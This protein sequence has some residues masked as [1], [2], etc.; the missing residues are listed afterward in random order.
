MMGVEVDV[1]TLKEYPFSK[2]IFDNLCDADYEA[3]KNDI[4]KHGIKVPLHIL[5]DFTVICGH[6]RLRV[7]KDLRMKS[8]PCEVKNLKGE[9][10]IKLWAIDDNLLRR[11]LTPEQRAML[12]ATK[13]ELYEIK[14][15]RPKK[16]AEPALLLEDIAAKMKVSRRTLMTARSYK[17]AIEELPELKCK[18][19]VNSVLAEYQ[20]R[21]DIEKRKNEIKSAPELKNL[22]HG[23]AVIKVDEIP[24]GSIGCVVTD[25]PYGNES[26]RGT[27][28]QQTIELRGGEKKWTIKG[29]DL[30]IFDLLDKFFTKLKPKL[31]ENA[32]LYIFTSWK[33]WHLLYPVVA[34]HYEVKNM[35]VWNKI[36]G[37][38]GE[39][40]GYN[41][42]E[43]FELVL[44]AVNGGK[45]KLN[46]E[47]EK[48]LNLLTVKPVW[49]PDRLHPNEKPIDLLKLLISYSTVEGETVLDPFAG[50]GSTL[51]AA[52][53]LG[54]NWIGI[55]IDPQWYE[56]AKMQI[57]EKRG[58]G[59]EKVE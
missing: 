22:I 48:P 21:K 49:N 33:R 11:Q 5:S 1:S 54:R 19:T 51:A 56:I 12:I 32:H 44:F 35:L 15:G 59:K 28:R 43:C 30:A 24:N 23:D 18:G 39:H 10:E 45:R 34:K 7:A 52:E 58:G 14:K 38:L 25:P 6:Q 55:E 57:H 53:E 13:S 36:R 46:Y 4:T 47:G 16:S 42:M 8:V 9:I 29:D 31:K 2:E 17:R 27:A 3:L 40:H 50:S 41:F 26:G 37:F 20:R